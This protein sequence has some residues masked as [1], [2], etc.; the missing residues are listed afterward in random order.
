MRKIKAAL[1]VAW[2]AAV[3]AMV[4]LLVPQPIHADSDPAWYDTG[5]GYRN[6]ITIDH[7]MVANTNQSDFAVLV[8]SIYPAWKD[9]ANGGHVEQ[10]DGGDILFTSSDGLTKLSHEIE[11]Y[12]SA[13]GELIAWV[14]VP[15]VSASSDTIIYIY[16]GNAVCADQWATDGSTWLS[17]YRGV[18]HF[19]EDP[20]GAA[21]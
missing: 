8:N 18:W 16:Y 9:T 15:T 2:I 3:V 20:S 10:S 13:T 7:D 1:N 5:W 17:N 12:T 6:T 19:K 4:V 11:R 14:K 21:P